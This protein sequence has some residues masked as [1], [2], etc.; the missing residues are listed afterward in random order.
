MNS[1]YLHSEYINNEA[2]PRSSET[3]QLY[4]EYT[5]SHSLLVKIRN[6]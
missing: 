4:K 5:P 2:L 3:A 6:N 1:W